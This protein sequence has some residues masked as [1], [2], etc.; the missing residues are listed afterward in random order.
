MEPTA[1]KESDMGD[2][3]HSGRHGGTLIALLLA[4]ALLS[5]ILLNSNC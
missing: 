3:P 1:Q 2:E 5:I 4:A